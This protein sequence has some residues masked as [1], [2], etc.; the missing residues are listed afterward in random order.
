[1]FGERDERDEQ[2]WVHERR[3]TGENGETVIELDEG[4]N[5]EELLQDL[6]A[7][8]RVGNEEAQFRRK[9]SSLLRKGW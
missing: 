1:M 9:I 4:G 8:V 3:L 2:A 6:E 7:T 5:S